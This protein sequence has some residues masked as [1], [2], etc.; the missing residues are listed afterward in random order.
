MK[1]YEVPVDL[2]YEVTETKHT[3]E[4]V[5][6]KVHIKR[7]IFSGQHESFY[8]L[9]ELDYSNRDY[10]YTDEIGYLG[11]YDAADY[12]LRIYQCG[13]LLG[14]IDLTDVVNRIK[15]EHA[16][17]SKGASYSKKQGSKPLVGNKRKTT[18]TKGKP[19]KDDSGLS[20]REKALWTTSLGM[21]TLS[22]GIALASLDKKMQDYIIVYNTQKDIHGIEARAKNDDDI[23]LK[24]IQ[25]YSN[26]QQVG[27]WKKDSNGGMVPIGT[28]WYPNYERPHWLSED[29][30][31]GGIHYIDR[32]TGKMIQ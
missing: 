20:R 30:P 19:K 8:A 21:S 26:H 31:F 6:A 17:G 25:N 24:V 22:L 28:M 23:R 5:T 3:G 14:T 27:I 12:R 16:G 13:T 1:K 29:D 18:F 32:N 11:E 10:I 9:L 2:H 15:G 4:R 7:I